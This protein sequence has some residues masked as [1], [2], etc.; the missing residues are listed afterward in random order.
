[1]CLGT[2]TGQLK[3]MRFCGRIL[4]N[5]GQNLILKRLEPW[6][7]RDKEAATLGDFKV[8]FGI[9]EAPEGQCLA[10]FC[11]QTWP[12]DRCERA[13]PKNSVEQTTNQHSI[14]TLTPTMS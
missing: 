13:E 3:L 12:W 2:A 14:P 11:C 5:A 10:A 6:H 1:M 8:E 4:P 7:T 9:W